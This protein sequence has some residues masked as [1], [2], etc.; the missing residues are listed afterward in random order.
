MAVGLAQDQGSV[1]SWAYQVAIGL[2]Q[3]FQRARE[4]QAFIQRTG[5]AAL[6]AAPYSF[7]VADVNTLTSAI[8]DAVNL[9]NIYNGTATQAAT[10]DFTQFLKQLRG[11]SCW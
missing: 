9:G 11:V 4:L 7:S 1:N 5:A 2:E 8:N 6:E 3:S 10:Y